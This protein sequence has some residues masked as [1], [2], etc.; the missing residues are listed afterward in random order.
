MLNYTLMISIVIFGVSSS[1]VIE[2]A[3]QVSIGCCPEQS[4]LC[5]SWLADLHYKSNVYKHQLSLIH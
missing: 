3:N 4:S 1:I 2:C 5:K